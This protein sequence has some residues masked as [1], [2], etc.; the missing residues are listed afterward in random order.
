MD[1]YLP[2]IHGVLKVF[3]ASFSFWITFLNKKNV[4]LLI[5]SSL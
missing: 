1:C 3:L 4:N 5:Y 2:V